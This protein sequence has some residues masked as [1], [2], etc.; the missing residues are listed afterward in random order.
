M[1]L[2]LTEL[3]ETGLLQFGLFVESAGHTTPYRLSLELLPSYPNLLC[4]TV[5]QASSFLGKVDLLLCPSAAI[6]LGTALSLS[7]GIPLV[8]SRGS[9][10]TPAEDLVGAYDIG[11]PACLIANRLE[12]SLEDLVRD[13]RQVGIEVAQAIIIVDEGIFQF[14]DLKT[15]SLIY[16]NAVIELLLQS[17]QIPAGQAHA[18]QHWILANRHPN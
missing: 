10:Q 1:T 2:L 16:L 11:H 15:Q 14:S 8:Y 7:S 9:R 6:P 17:K 12:R 18:V 3:L 13:A 5:D 4:E